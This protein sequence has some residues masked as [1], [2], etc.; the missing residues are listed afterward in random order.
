MLDLRRRQFITLLGGAA[1]AWPPAARTQQMAARRVAVLLASDDSNMED[2]A[3][4]NALLR[5][6]QQLGW[7]DGRNL[8]IDVRWARGSLQQTEK[9]VAEVVALAPEV[10]VSSGSVATATFQRATPTIPVVFALVNEPVAQGFVASL[11]RPGGNITGFTNTD[12]S[13]LGKWVELLKTMVPALDRVGLLF[14]AP[15]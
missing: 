11:A 2:Q 14:N 7:S 10:I 9:M 4:L 8:A 15:N 13:V 12:F 1:A 3:R 5:D 6:L